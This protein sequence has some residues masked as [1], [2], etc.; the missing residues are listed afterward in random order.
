MDPFYPKAPRMPS[1]RSNT[2]MMSR[3]VRPDLC[4]AAAP[5][6]SM[7][8]VGLEGEVLHRTADPR[9]VT[10][11]HIPPPALSAVLD[12]GLCHDGAWVTEAVELRR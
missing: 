3:A 11:I 2:S 6:M 9:G 4:G 10:P 7:G 1:K 12:M 8:V 5:Q